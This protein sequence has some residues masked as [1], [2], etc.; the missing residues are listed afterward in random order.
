MGGDMHQKQAKTR[1][2]DLEL[3][4]GSHPDAQNDPPDR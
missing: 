4:V 3:T 1:T 2:N